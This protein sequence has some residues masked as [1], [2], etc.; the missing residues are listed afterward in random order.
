[1]IDLAVL[2]SARHLSVQDSAFNLAMVYN[3]YL[4]HMRSA[5]TDAV[6][7]RAWSKSAFAVVRRLTSLAPLHEPVAEA[8]ELSVI[9]RPLSACSR[10]S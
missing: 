3:G 7:G 2:I 9:R 1:V 5:A 10:S 8:D 6:V 4:T